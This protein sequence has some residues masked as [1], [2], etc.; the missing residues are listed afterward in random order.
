LEIKENPSYSH[1]PIILI[2]AVNGIDEIAASC[3]A[4]DLIKKPFD[5]YDFEQ[6]VSKWLGLSYA[7][8]FTT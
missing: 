1:I 5:I 2:S 8:N 4:D 6:I 7:S 3:K